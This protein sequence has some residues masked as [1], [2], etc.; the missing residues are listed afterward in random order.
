MASKSGDLPGLTLTAATVSELLS[1]RPPLTALEANA[2][3]E[4]LDA[5]L[6]RALLAEDATTEPL[7]IAA[8][9]LDLHATEFRL[10]VLALAAELDPRYQRC[11]GLL[12]DDL[13]RRA[14][15]L[16]LFLEMLGEPSQVCATNWRGQR[17]SR[18]GGSS[19]D[20]REDCRGPTRPYGSTAGCANG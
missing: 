4:A 12:I 15:T 9:A 2:G 10:M 11:F 20:K 7:A 19:M 1:A 3:V 18:D 13:G 16:G 17:N 5:A 6:T 14:G 8:H